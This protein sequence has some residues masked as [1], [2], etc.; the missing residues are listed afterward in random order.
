MDLGRYADELLTRYANP[1]IRHRTWQ[2]AMDGSQ[3]LPQRLLA[4]IRDD[5][6]E[7][8]PIPCLALAV[9]GW[10]RYVG[11]TDERGRAIDVRDPLAAEL[12]DDLAA[13]GPDPAAQ[14]R[15]ALR[16]QSVF[17][18][19]LPADATF[20]AA[21]TTACGALHRLGARGAVAALGEA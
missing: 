21:V 7:A 20:V 17:G 3:K 10:I 16:H 1:A 13:A 5:L 8:R 14:V 15:A 4:T 2:I 9:A 12:R 6:R 18:T 11:G 19:D